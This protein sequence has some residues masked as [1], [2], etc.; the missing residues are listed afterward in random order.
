MMGTKGKEL[1]VLMLTASL[2][3]G[4]TNT[5]KE[6]TTTARLNAPA[7]EEQGSVYTF[8]Y[9]INKTGNDI[10]VRASANNKELFSQKVASK[11]KTP[12]EGRVYPPTGE[13]PTMELKVEVN[14]GAKTLKV[15]ET[16]SGL[17]ASFDITDFSTKGPG[18]SIMIEGDEISLNQDYYPIR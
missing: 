2:L 14:R 1:F 7:T 4:C 8:F 16:N 18:F 15:Q 17:E 3:L 6:T 12:A 10:E 13:Y 11:V 9:I 5:K